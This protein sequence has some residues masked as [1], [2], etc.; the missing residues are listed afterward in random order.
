M[1]SRYDAIQFVLH[2]AE[3]YQGDWTDFM[4]KTC[5]MF[6]GRLPD[7]LLYGLKRRACNELNHLC[8]DYLAKNFEAL[9]RQLLENQQR[10]LKVKKWQEKRDK[11]NILALQKRHQERQKMKAQDV[12]YEKTLEE[13]SQ[14]SQVEWNGLVQDMQVQRICEL[15]G[16]WKQGV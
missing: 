14:K 7:S 4:K 5:K 1:T 3:F 10:E 11:G 8:D 2:T 6:R 13:P 16:I 12:L 15:A 9:E